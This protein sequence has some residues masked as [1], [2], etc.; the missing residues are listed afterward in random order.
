VD[1]GKALTTALEGKRA[2]VT[3]ASRGLGV[4]IARA[5][6]DAGSSLLL[7]A[8]SGAALASLRDS[9]PRVPGQEAHCAVAD[10]GAPEAASTVLAAARARWESLDV[11]VNNA[12][13]QGPIG[14]AWENDW[15]EWQQALRVHLLGPIALCRAVAPW[16]AARKAGKIINISGGGATSARPNFS[17]YAVAKTGLVRFSECL[18]AELRGDRVDV[19]CIAPGAM[20]SEMTRAVL[21]AGPEAA[22]VEYEQA[23]KVALEGGADAGRAAALCVFLASAES[24]GI[25]GRLLSALWDPWQG[26]AARRAELEASD[27]YTLRRIVPRDRGKT[28]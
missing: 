28:W 24:D 22:G 27:I 7:V 26:L 3:G 25:S 18:A 11:L 8:R 5:F 15:K 16:M 14:R 10:L 2:I 13:Q 20:N 19:N 23:R 1:A 17:S 12:A 4:A 9:L 21:R 6:W